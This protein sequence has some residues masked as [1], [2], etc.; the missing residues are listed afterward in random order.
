[1]ILSDEIRNKYDIRV[2]RDMRPV[3]IRIRLSDHSGKM[4]TL[5]YYEGEEGFCEI[6]EKLGNMYGVVLVG[7]FLWVMV[8]SKELDLFHPMKVE[9]VVAG[10]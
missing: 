6:A 5:A 8:N 2:F 3:A 7:G 1:M 10:M 9:S 4:K